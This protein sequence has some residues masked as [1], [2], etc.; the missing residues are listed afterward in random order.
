[1]ALIN[2]VITPRD[3]HIVDVGDYFADGL[4][5]LINQP[6]SVVIRQNYSGT[7]LLQVLEAEEDV[8]NDVTFAS[9]ADAM[10]CVGPLYNIIWIV[11]EN[12][13]FFMQACEFATH[14]Y[15]C[16][17]IRSACQEIP[18]IETY[19][20]KI[21]TL[22]CKTHFWEIWGR[23]P[24]TT[25]VLMICDEDWGIARA[26][27]IPW[28]NPV[29]RHWFKLYTLGQGIIMGR[30]TWESLRF[31]P[32]PGRYNIVL[33]TTL[34]SG[35]GYQVFKTLKEAV[36]FAHSKNL[37]AWIIGGARPVEVS[38]TTNAISSSLLLYIFRRVTK[39]PIK[40]T[41]LWFVKLQIQNVTSLCHQYPRKILQSTTWYHM[42]IPS[43]R[44]GNEHLRNCRQRSSLLPT[45]VFTGPYKPRVK[46]GN[47]CCMT[48][49]IN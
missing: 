18:D 48:C 13:P 2:I 28:N 37:E 44:C 36:S 32:L 22:Q 17:N 49:K 34:K 3:Q 47:T 9:L 42:V 20:R 35:N 45:F 26:G 1:M 16:G 40:Y 25:N 27:K 39:L 43:S 8:E 15:S 12:V 21:D 6:G 41:R 5:T 4:E 10:K 31:K 30:E 23:K 19:F 14:V 38:K 33:S 46:N 24:N 7:V 29:D 11:I